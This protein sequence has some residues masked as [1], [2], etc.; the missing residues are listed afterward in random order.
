[1]SYK[2]AHVSTGSGVVVAIGTIFDDPRDPKQEQS[3]VR[4]TGKVTLEDNNGVIFFDERLV[5]SLIRYH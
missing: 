4:Y 3:V 2:I 1:M 5:K